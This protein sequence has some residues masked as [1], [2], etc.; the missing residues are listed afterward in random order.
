MLLSSVPW[1]QL[2]SGKL[3]LGAKETGKGV[4]LWGIPIRIELDN[5]EYNQFQKELGCIVS[6]PTHYSSNLKTKILV[7]EL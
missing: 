2:A 4:A 6:R 1:A 3:I 7:P 5:D